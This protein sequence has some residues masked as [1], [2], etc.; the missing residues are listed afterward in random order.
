MKF[1]TL[2]LEEKRVENTY[3]IDKKI[4]TQWSSDC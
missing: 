2:D 1:I 4:K 3:T